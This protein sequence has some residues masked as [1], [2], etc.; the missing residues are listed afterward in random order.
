MKEGWQNNRFNERVWNELPRKFSLED[1]DG[2]IRFQYVDEKGNLKARLILYEYKSPVENFPKDAQLKTLNLLKRSID[3]SKLDKR[4]GVFLI[5]GLDENNDRTEIYELIDMKW[6]NKMEVGFDYYKDWFYKP[7]QLL[8][9][10]RT[11]PCPKCGYQMEE[12]GDGSIDLP[13]KNCGWAYEI[14]VD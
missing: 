1:I 5:K 9:T 7:E 13:C 2:V 12:Y 6:E 11:T 8:K 10:G 4:S 3:W 14:K